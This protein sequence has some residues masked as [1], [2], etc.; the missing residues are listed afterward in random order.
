[1]AHIIKY[2]HDEMIVN[3]AVSDNNEIVDGCDDGEVVD[4]KNILSDKEQELQ[5]RND[6]LENECINL[7]SI[8]EEQKNT[9]NLMD[10]KIADS[11]KTSVDKGFLDGVEQGKSDFL[12]QVQEKLDNFD[13]LLCEIKTNYMNYL[14]D[15][16]DDILDI[17]FSSVTSI[18]AKEYSKDVLLSIV[19]SCIQEI[20]TIDDIKLHLSSE[21][22]ELFSD[23]KPEGPI[24]KIIVDSRVR[25]GGCI[26][27]S[28][29]ER[30]DCRLDTKLSI[31]KNLLLDVN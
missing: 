5:L 29:K 24:S 4:K 6:Y 12:K 8:I 21:D 7:S 2:S 28:T 25:Y 27:E 20:D 13:N 19:N 1:M 17:I 23:F 16:S 26:I 9:I 10:E 18:I 15:S 11:I 3:D 22:F 30:I 14:Y 31:F